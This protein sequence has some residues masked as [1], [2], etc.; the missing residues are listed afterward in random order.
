MN[1]RNHNH[2]SC[3]Q[4]FTLIEILVSMMIFSVILIAVSSTF[5]RQLVLQRHGFAA[6]K[7]QENSL[8]VMEQMARDIRVSTI[9]G[10]DQPGINASCNGFG[11]IAH[12][13]TMVHPVHGT[14]T[15]SLYNPDAN[16]FLVNRNVN[17]IDT[18]ISSRD[19]QFTL[20]QFCIFG[21][22]KDGEQ[23]RV[24]IIATV[25]NTSTVPS[26]VVSVHF[27]TT[28]ATRELTTELGP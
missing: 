11:V 25:Q 15:Y 18:Y 20:F 5:A 13:V 23:A 4:G 26:N 1:Y 2:E 3:E 9:T 14:I 28:I 21:A 16:T 12:S 27:Q 19:V 22:G 17:G 8:Y 24:A 10:S 6:Q 7:V